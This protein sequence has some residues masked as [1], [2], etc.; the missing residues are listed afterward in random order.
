MPSIWPL[1]VCRKAKN[2]NH[3]GSQKVFNSLKSL[4]EQGQV[5][6]AYQ[7]LEVLDKNGTNVS[8]NLLYC[9]LQGCMISK[10]IH[11]GRHVQSF[12]RKK[13]LQTSTYL[14]SHLI[15]LFALC[16]SLSEAQQVFSQ[17]QHPN[18]FAWSAI[19]SA[20]AKLG[21]GE[22]AIKFYYSLRQS[23]LRMD[24]QIFVAALQA[25]SSLQSLSEGKC[26]HKH[27]TESGFE[28]DPFVMC[29][30]VDMYAQCEK[31]ADAFSVFKR[32]PAKNVVLWNTMIAAYAQQGHLLTACKLVERMKHEGL[33]PNTETWNAMIAGCAQNGYRKLAICF[34]QQMQDTGMK[35]NNVTWNGMIAGF[36]RHGDV[37]EAFQA[38]QQMQQFGMEPD[39]LTYVSVLKACYSVAALNHVNLVH[40][41][42]I[43]NG[44]GLDVVT[45]NSVIQAYTRCGSLNEAQ[46]VFERHQQ[47]G[48]EEWNSI[49]L[50]YAHNSKHELALSCFQNMCQQGVHPD[51]VTFTS[52]LSA[53]SHLG[54]VKEGCHHFLLMTAKYGL[55]P[56]QEHVNCMVDLLG[57]SGSLIQAEDL[58]WTM[59]F[60][61][62]DVALRSLLAHCR[63]HSEM[64]LGHQCYGSVVTMDTKSLQIM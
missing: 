27:I 41:Q 10:N 7:L 17:L 56:I 2:A 58:L 38:F 1:N 29:S 31:L 47:R 32:V 45:G 55:M 37:Q 20:H 33:Q 28:L 8:S 4:C 16:G 44:S 24:G 64:K 59:P 48:V 63:T 36:A 61:P 18:L 60:C 13:N 50:G 53:Y 3:S 19:I 62:D 6:T 21:N 22:E 25:C 52:L 43:E 34:L 5:T 57:R 14:G 35:P 15:R 12:I 26:I 11:I 40:A 42:M 46:R 9:I 51:L 39:Q 23:A 54:S 30:L 49:L